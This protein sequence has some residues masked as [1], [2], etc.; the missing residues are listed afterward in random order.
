[1]ATLIKTNG[2]TQ[3]VSPK[4]GQCFTLEELQGFVGG[5]IE[6]VPIRTSDNRLMVVNEEGLLSDLPSNR[7]ATHELLRACPTQYNPIVGD[8]LLVTDEEID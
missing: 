8:V 1:M 4:S 5:Y 6:I 2:T 7:K 3:E